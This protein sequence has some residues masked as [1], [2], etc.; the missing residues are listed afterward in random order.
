MSIYRSLLV[1]LALCALPI[2]GTPAAHAD[3]TAGQRCAAGVDNDPSGR[4]FCA[5]QAGI[6]ISNGPKVAAG[7]PCATP[8]D[9]R[10]KAG[11]MEQ[12]NVTCR[13]GVWQ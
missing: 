8:G 4:L 13:G 9:V 12:D 10:L 2:A 11:G 6:W 5:G 1:A 3:P 7:S